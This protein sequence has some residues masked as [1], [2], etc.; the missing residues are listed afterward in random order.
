MLAHGLA[1]GNGPLYG[2]DW[3][4]AHFVYCGKKTWLALVK[5]F[6]SA[7]FLSIAGTQSVMID[8]R[9]CCAINGCMSGT[10]VEG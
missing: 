8:L 5:T 7:E 4:H 9:V 2:L 3:S 6:E 10:N 1:G